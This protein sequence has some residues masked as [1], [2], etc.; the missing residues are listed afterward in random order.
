MGRNNVTRDARGGSDFGLFGRR[1]VGTGRA[2]VGGM[3]TITITRLGQTPSSDRSDYARVDVEHALE[4]FRR[5]L[6]FL[7][8]D[9]PWIPAPKNEDEYSMVQAA[10]AFREMLA[11][12]YCVRVA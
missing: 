7:S 3:H 11:Y 8:T 10:E 5:A 1:V 4:N 12:G 9:T 2:S 6:Y